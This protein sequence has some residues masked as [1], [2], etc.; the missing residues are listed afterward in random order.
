MTETKTNH[1]TEFASLFIKGVERAAE[2]QKKSLDDAARQNA[3]AIT[4][5]KKRPQPVPSTPAVYDLAGQAFEGYIEA[6]K[7]VIDHVVKQTTSLFESAKDNGN[8]AQR[9]A[10]DFTKTVQQSIER[11]VEVQKKALDLVTQE[12][13]AAV[14]SKRTA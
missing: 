5:Y 7:S 1:P 11:A 10:A 2:L 4:A 14:A 9:I 8:S 12:S 3:E 6:Q 13:K